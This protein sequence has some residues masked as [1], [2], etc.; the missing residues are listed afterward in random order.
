VGDHIPYVICKQ[1]APAPSDITAATAA[2][3]PAPAPMVA[4]GGH[5]VADRAF[6]PDEGNKSNGTLLIDNDWYVSQQVYPPV[7]RLCEP[8]EGT[9]ASM[10][11]ECLGMS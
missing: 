6:H 8:I 10:L 9:S 7:Q 11:A 4:T 2:G 3:A 5:G 1:V